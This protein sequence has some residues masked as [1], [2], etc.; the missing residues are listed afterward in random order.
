MMFI[1]KKISTQFDPVISNVW[2][3]SGLVDCSG[4]SIFII[5]NDYIVTEEYWGKHSKDTNS[6]PIQ[7]DTQFHVASVRKSYIGFAVAY[8]VH[9]GYIGST[10]DSIIKYFPQGDAQILNGT[11]IRLVI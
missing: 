2:K 4:A 8:A 7:E 10:N 1:H 6:I 11:T 9:K 5:H 3:T